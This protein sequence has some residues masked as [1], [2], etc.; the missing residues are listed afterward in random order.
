LVASVT[1]FVGVFGALIGSFLNVV[2]YRVPLGRSIVSPPSACGSCGHPVRG[3]DNIP[4]ISWLVLRGKCRD[5][6]ARISVRYPLVELG[7]AVFFVVVA[8]VFVPRIFAVWQTPLIAA[9]ILELVAFLYLAAISLALALIDLETYKL[10]NSIVLPAYAVGGVL[11]G[12]AGLLSGSYAAMLTAAIGALG[13]GAVYLLLF[14]VIPG[15]MGFGDVKLAGVIGLFLGYLGWG[16]LVVGAFSAFVL[17]GLFSVILLVSRRAKA[18][19]KVPFGP[20]MLGGAWLGILAG[21]PIAAWYIA[22]FG[23]GGA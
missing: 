15:G 11:L 14:L 18:K 3:Y 20:W 6:G 16:P 7:G 5:C 23:L 12:V 17:G 21:T 19:S 2:I 9:G 10:P 1:A 8:L 4:L 13:L 22:L